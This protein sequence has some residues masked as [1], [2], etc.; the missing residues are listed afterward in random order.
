M[1]SAGGVP[2]CTGSAV[3][4][5]RLR[6]ATRPRLRLRSARPVESQ[7]SRSRFRWRNAR[8]QPTQN[9]ADKKPARQ[10]DVDSDYLFDNAQYP[11]YDDD[12]R[13]SGSNARRAVLGCCENDPLRTKSTPTVQSRFPGCRKLLP[14]LTHSQYLC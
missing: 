5:S 13:K 14:W 9:I 7:S 12:L 6:V 10:E 1:K 3:F 8:K 2:N 11:S 4:F